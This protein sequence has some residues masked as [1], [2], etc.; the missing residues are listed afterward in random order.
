MT[1]ANTKPTKVKTG[2]PP[3]VD[4]L[5]KPAVG[6]ALA[7]LAYQFFKGISGEVSHDDHA[8]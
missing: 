6:I 3:P 7:L 4:K 2:S 8:D 1:A 5:L